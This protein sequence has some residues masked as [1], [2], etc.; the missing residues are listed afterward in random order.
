MRRL[1]K[2]GPD[3]VYF[4]EIFWNTSCKQKAG[5]HIAAS[6]E[7][8]RWQRDLKALRF[9][10]SPHNRYGFH[11][12]DMHDLLTKNRSDMIENHFAT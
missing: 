8:E 11:I 9:Q 1:E 6:V 7:G 3:A 12:F 2:V 10:M 5:V 4:K